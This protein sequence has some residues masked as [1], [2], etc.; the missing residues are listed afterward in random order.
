MDCL[1]VGVGAINGRNAASTGIAPFFMIHGWNQEV[2]KLDLLP[3]QA[4]ES[5][6]SKADR[7]LQKLKDVRDM[8]EASIAAAQD[9]QE[10][11]ANR[12]R[13]QAPVYRV[14]DKVWL[15]LEN[16]AT[17]RPSKKLDQRYAK[18]T[19]REVYGSHTYRLDV[20]PGRYDVFP[21]RLLRPVNK[22]LDGQIVTEPHPVGLRVDGEVEYGV[23]EIRDQKR[24]RGGSD[25]YLVKWSGYKKPTWEPWDFVKDLIALEHWE[26][27]KRDGHVP[28]G[29]RMG[30][31]RKRRGLM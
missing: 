8:A 10:S 1:Q 19:V 4:R 27:R 25:L 5:P 23:D 2:F 18:Y 7:V 31:R 11:A 12:K 16:I 29:G 13:D 24:G 22:P 17:E 30:V 20:P 28:L 26:A 9:S 6:V 3:T 15:S 21:T 14:G